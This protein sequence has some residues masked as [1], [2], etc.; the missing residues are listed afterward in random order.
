[1]DRRLEELPTRAEL[2]T[3]VAEMASQVTT[4]A[5]GYGATLQALQRDIRRLSSKV[6]TKDRDRDVVLKD[7]GKRITALERR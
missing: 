2:R 6:T 4:A 1:M 3:F 5:E 7:H